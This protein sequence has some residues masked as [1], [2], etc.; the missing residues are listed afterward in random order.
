[1]AKKNRLTLG[2]TD[3]ASFP[4]LDL[5]NI[6]I[7]MDTGAYTSAIHCHE[8][9]QKTAN[10]KELVSFSLLDPS[11]PA[12]TAARFEFENFEQRQIKNSFGIAES[13]F[14]IS[15]TILLFGQEYPI[16]L[17]LSARG[18]MKYP[19]LIGRKFLV[20]NFVVDPAKTNLSFKHMKSK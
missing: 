5:E 16:E 18:E 20:G 17:S 8:I 14:I 15:T 2:R 11:H 6:A 3:I 1:M 4:L 9:E 7:K 19:V 12:Y 10:G 13:R